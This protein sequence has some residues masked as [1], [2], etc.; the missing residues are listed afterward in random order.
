MSVMLSML[1]R[2]GATLV[3]RHGRQVPLDFGNPAAEAAV[4]RRSV[5]LAERS[6]RATLE[7]RG[8]RVDVDRAVAE[9]D[10]LGGRAWPARLSPTLALVRCEGGDDGAVTSAMLRAEVWVRDVSAEY[11][12]MELV[13][14]L[15]LEVLQAANVDPEEDPVTVL[16]EGEDYVELLVIGGYGPA[17]WNRLLEAGEPSGIACVG[18]D[19]LEH[20]TVSERV[21]LTRR[22]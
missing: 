15:A 1:R 12:A 5:G 20:I 7:V 4:C 21:R 11:A 2:H 14:P 13:G 16:L 22:Q 8:P 3:E 19:A 18:L 6:D 9:L 10:T 17:L